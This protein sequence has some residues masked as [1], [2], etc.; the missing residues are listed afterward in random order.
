[1]A[2][3]EKHKI[4][5]DWLLCGDLKGLQRMMQAKAE[6]PEIPEAQRKEIMRL[7]SALTPQKQ[8]IGFALLRELM[9]RSAPNG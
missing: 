4:S 5:L 3:A 2:F 7:F 8:V 6:P 1:L 9:V